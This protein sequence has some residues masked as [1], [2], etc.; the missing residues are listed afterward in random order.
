MITSKEIRN[1]FLNYFESKGH[2]KVKSASLIPIDDPTLI[3]VNA[4]MVP[5]KNYFLGKETPPYVRATSSQKCM[6][7]SGKHN[8]L[9]HV[10]KTARHHTCFEMLGNFSFGD[11][12]K[13]D[14]IFYGWDFLTNTLKLDPKDLW[15]TIYT[16][17]DEAEA[18]WINKMGVSP[19]RVVK[20][21]EKS[22]FWAMG[23]TG[24][25]G[26]C[27]EIHIDQ[28]EE[29]K[30]G[31][32]CGIGV[33]DCDRFLELWN[34]VFMQYE[35]S[36]N[37]TLTPL[38]KPSIDTGMGL[39]RVTS[40]IQ[41][42]KSNYDSDI[43]QPIINFIS[44]LINQEYYSE[45]PDGM[46]MRVIAD[47][48]RATAFLIADG[49]IPSNEGRGYVL[50]RVMRRA[51]RYGKKLGFD[52]IF[53]AK[54]AIFVTEL[55]GD[56]YPELKKEA[57][58]IE[59]IVDNE[60]S[61]FRKTLDTGE[62]LLFNKMEDLK[63]KNSNIIDGDTLFL[64][65]DAYGF[66]I[67]LCEL[68][69]SE[70][71]FEIDSKGFQNN[72]AVQ[73]ARS[74]SN[75]KITEIN[76]NFDKLLF[77]Y[78]QKYSKIEFLG[79]NEL[80]IEANLVAIID[81]DSF[82]KSAIAD[83]ENLFVFI[84]DKTA[85]Y[86]ES[87]GQGADKGFIYQNEAIAEVIDVQK[88]VNSI[89]YHTVKIIKGVFEIEKQIT[90]KV[91]RNNRLQTARNHSATHLLQAAL[92]E[93]VGAHIH[94]EG[95]RV[96][97]DRLRFDFNHFE[98]LTLDELQQIEDYV[99]F[100]IMD[101]EETIIKEMGIDEAKNSGATA[102]FQEKY[103]DIVR[104]VKVS[105]KS[106]ELCGGT[107]VKRSGDIGFF[108]IISESSI[109]SGIRRIEATTG[110]K[111]LKLIHIQEKHERGII[112]ILKASKA[113]YI[114]KV[115]ELVAKN[116]QLEKELDD[117]KKELAIAKLSSKGKSNDILEDINGVLVLFKILDGVGVSEMKGIGDD[118]KQKH[119]KSLIALATKDS[120]GYQMIFMG[121]D[122]TIH[123]GNLLKSFLEPFGG[124]GGGKE[125][126]AQGG[127][128]SSANSDELK[129]CL[130]N[131]LTNR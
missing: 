46:A 130:V 88:D 131:L 94:Q 124:R 57:F 120:K 17:D 97:S 93:I 109:A 15:I 80:E 95:S 1:A 117:I 106:F 73:R 34:L 60:E 122:S 128:S 85:F 27:S 20:L 56:I 53:F 103:G 25:C 59:K 48:A 21:G 10:G 100:R 108:K 86:A 90:L 116:R 69:A 33:C 65:Y 89:I 36:E 76:Q 8:D 104:T 32:D 54:V 121:G 102:L 51:V 38:P 66:P 92:K 99:N 23:D 29:M 129:S 37:G 18:I 58:T 83:D 115:K 98:G 82:E 30:C 112:S 31:P 114:D 43:F 111:A 5:F 105:S 40:V 13:E 22:N 75:R 113:S 39:E 118:L 50:R 44:N 62:K 91:D 26:P 45:T 78:S 24:P 35:R 11:Y 110:E 123:C 74:R 19:E 55:M 119:P 42:K 7:V 3:F 67:D 61:K 14:A 71:G 28:G 12:F 72:L 52:K 127:C 81:E 101:N 68:I 70:N 47:H 64:L 41:G 6:R 9:E 2:Q 16:D 79:Y 96:D 87:G 77:E 84:S 107:H 126:M 49:V 125:G 63:S 4:G